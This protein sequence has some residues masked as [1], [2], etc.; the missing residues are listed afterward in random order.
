LVL[1]DG[2]HIA[3]GVE[4]GHQGF[5]LILT[6]LEILTQKVIALQKNF[7]FSLHLFESSFMVVT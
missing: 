2:G 6:A 7:N 1:E 4:M 5:D 3:A